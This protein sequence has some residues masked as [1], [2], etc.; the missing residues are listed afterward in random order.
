MGEGAGVS[1]YSI[2][3]GK[4]TLHSAESPCITGVGTVSIVS[5]AFASQHRAV[6]SHSLF[7]SLPTIYLLLFLAFWPL[8]KEISIASTMHSTRTC[9]RA[10]IF[11]AET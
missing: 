6:R 5:N 10:P 3:R 7:L 1:V 2:E 8:L 4:R 9:L 11:R